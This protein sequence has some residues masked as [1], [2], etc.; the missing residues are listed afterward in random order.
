VSPIEDVTVHEIVVLQTYL[1][2][3]GCKEAAAVLGV[4]AQSV[5]NTLAAIRS[6]L[7]VPRTA[8][9]VIILAEFLRK[10]AA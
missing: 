6:K 3:G 8:Q 4:G 9:A 5:K 10:P 1:D 7:D 2:E